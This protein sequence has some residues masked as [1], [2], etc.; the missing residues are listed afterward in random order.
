M[1]NTNNS[2]P[3]YWALMV[4]EALSP[5]SGKKCYCVKDFITLFFRDGGVGVK[6]DSLFIYLSF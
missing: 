5:P 1:Y 2:I 6:M 4:C 3:T